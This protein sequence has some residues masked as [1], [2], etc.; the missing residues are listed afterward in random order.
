M[1]EI[2]ETISH[3]KIVK[4]IGS[5]GMGVVYE[6]D[7]TSLGRPV[8]LKFLPTEVL[9]SPAAKDRFLR[10]AR[11]AAA[12]NHPGICIVHEI[13]AHEG[14][15]FIAMELLEG[16][17]L[18]HRIAARA[19]GRAHVD[20]DELLDLAIQI[21]DALNAAHTKGIIHRDVKPANIFIA[22]GG[23]AKILDFGLAKIPTESR[24]AAESEASTEE[25]LTS[26]GSAVGTVAYM[27]PEQARGEELDA[28]SDLFS[29]GVVLYEMATGQQA[30]TGSTS[31]VIFE[32]ILNK[33]PTSPVRLNPGLPAELERIINKALEKDR[34]LRYQSASE[35]RVDLQRL[36]R[37]SDSGHSMASVVAA[38]KKSNR[39][40]II[41][42][43]ALLVILLVAASGYFYFHRT[44]KLTNKDSIILADFTNTTGDNAWD[45][46][47][48]QGLVVGLQ[49]SPFLR[50]ISGDQIA[51]TLRLMEK[52]PDAKLT[53]D[54]ARQVCW[55]VGATATIEGSIANL[56]NQ[57]VIGLSAVN[58]KTGELLAQEQTTADGKLKVIAAL[59]DTASRLRSKLGESRESL[60]A[61]DTP[62]VQATTPSLE[63]L[64]AYIKGGQAFVKGDMISGITFYERAINLD[65]SFAM[66]YSIL[67]ATQYLV[68]SHSDQAIEN[69][70]KAYELRNRISEYEK[71]AL[72]KNYHIIVT[73]NYDKALQISQQWVRTYPHDW[74]ALMGLSD[75]NLELGRA[76]DALLQILEV[77][78]IFSTQMATIMACRAYLKLNRFDEVRAAIQQA[79]TRQLDSPSYGYYLYLSALYQN[80]QT[81]MA[82]NEAVMSRLLGPFG[83]DLGWAAYQGRLLRFRDFTQRRIALSLKANRKASAAM[84]KAQAAQF[85]AL[86]GNITEARKAAN[87]A[88][89]MFTHWE[90]QGNVA[91]T[92]ALAGDFAGAQKLASDLNQLFP[93][94]TAIQFC[95]L[96]AIRA[97]LALNKGNMKEAIKDFGLISPYELL[98]KPQMIAVYLRGTAYLA[99]RQGA[100]AVADFQK[101]LAYPNI[102]AFNGS[103]ALAHLGLGRAYV[104]QGDSAKARKE[105]QDFLALWKDADPDIPILKQ[106]NAEYAKLQ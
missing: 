51:Q 13:A 3:Y 60:K 90:V 79:R 50:I 85:E 36:K 83:L 69:S 96:P 77:N 55:R 46:T 58:C 48:K 74:P 41:G 31:A 12:L 45:A 53:H 100:Q 76:E 39:R 4:K 75:Q 98:Q 9:G 43:A 7:D 102:A 57:Y 35:L 17:T 52:P 5:G 103:Q 32:A 14:Q 27:S 89:N 97:V 70:K 104:L 87:E 62:L 33:A 25:F 65:P 101:I 64:Q 56:E 99:A 92:L 29:F 68:D 38:P 54:I 106:A 105:Y 91:L 42:A 21:A 73:G 30:F 86:V 6:A 84:L 10:E 28:R 24:K 59:G 23:Q 78:R 66:A 1:P 93:E 2:G 95:Y 63:A 16:E 72:L 8:A 81:G 15:Y 19:L 26:P 71:F 18:R 20:I 37:D 49:Q 67:S 40:M 82:T 94:A 44:P 61:Y 80:D 34:K 22:Q 88:S 47:L 11:A